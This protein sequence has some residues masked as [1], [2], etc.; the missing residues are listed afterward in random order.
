MTTGTFEG[1]GPPTSRQKSQK[2]WNPVAVE[3]AL[4][5]LK[6]RIASGVNIID[7]AYGEFS[8]AEEV[9]T[10]AEARAYVAFD[11]RPAH[12]RKYHVLIAT[13]QERKARLIKERVYKK[14]VTNMT[15]LTKGLDAVRSIGAGVRQAYENV[16]AG[17]R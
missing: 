11:D 6:N 9:Q 5:E 13:E 1:Y 14:A 8:D 17:E 16:G 3:A 2:D 4:W 10:M 12:E 7:D 15:A